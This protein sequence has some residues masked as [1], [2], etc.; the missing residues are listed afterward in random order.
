MSDFN[1]AKML[2]VIHNALLVQQEL[3]QAI[4]QLMAELQAEKS[5]NQWSSLE[6]GAKAL[7]PIFSARKILDDIKAGYLKYG[8]HYIDTSNGNRP[9]YAVKVKALRKVYENLPEKRQRYRPHDKKSA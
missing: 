3:N 9:T 6:D 2:E 1:Q 8:T 4:A 7:G 5:E